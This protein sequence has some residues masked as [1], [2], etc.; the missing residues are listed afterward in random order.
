MYTQFIWD[1]KAARTKREM[2][3]LNIERMSRH[4][5]HGKHILIF[6]LV[7]WGEIHNRYK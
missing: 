6:I 4:Y 3:M 7:T 2:L 5:S 1:E